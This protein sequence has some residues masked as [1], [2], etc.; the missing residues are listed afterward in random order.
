MSDH[1]TTKN[2]TEELRILRQLRN[3]RLAMAQTP[4][5]RAEAM[6]GLVLIT[7]EIESLCKA[8]HNYDMEASNTIER[9]SAVNFAQELS[10]IIK[11]ELMRLPDYATWPQDSIGIFNKAWNRVDSPMPYVF[12]TVQTLTQDVP[13]RVE[14]ANRLLVRIT[15]LVERLHNEPTKRN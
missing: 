7:K 1:L 14:V 11:D 10:A 5:E 8:V 4:A 3:D 6:P 2:L 12:D 9:D 13:D 15:E